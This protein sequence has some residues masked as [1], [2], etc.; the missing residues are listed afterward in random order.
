MIFVSKYFEVCPEALASPPVG[1]RREL[2]AIP[3]AVLERRV[4]KRIGKIQIQGTKVLPDGTELHV[5]W[6]VQ[7]NT[8]L[9]LPTEQDLDIF[10][11]L[12]VLTFQNNF[13]KTITFTGREIAKILGIQSVHGKFYQRLKMAMDRF[14]PLRF[15]GLG[16]DGSP[17]R[18][19]VVE[20]ISGSQLYPRS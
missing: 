6:Q 3:F 2:A 18:S 19:E 17:R 20:R 12:G 14:I 15:R 9:G 1:R 4:G 8:E 7:G 16:R 5:S 11:A 10:V 13:A